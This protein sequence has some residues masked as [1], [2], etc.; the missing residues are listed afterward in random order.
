MPDVHYL[1]SKLSHTIYKKRFKSFVK[2]KLYKNANIILTLRL[3]ST[4]KIS[5]HVLEA[6]TMELIVSILARLKIA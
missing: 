3:L 5:L 6:S 2:K 1:Q 4:I